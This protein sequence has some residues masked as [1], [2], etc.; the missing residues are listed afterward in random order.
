MIL[1]PFTF[2]KDSYNNE[3]LLEARKLEKLEIQ[4][5][6]SRTAKNFNCRCLA[7]KVTP[8]TLQIKL[9]G[10]RLE[11]AII[12]KAECSL[13]YN[14]IKCTNIKINHLQTKIACTKTSLQ[15]KLDEPT[16]TNLQNTIFNNKAKTFLQYKNTQIKK[17]KLLIS[18]F[19]TTSSKMA[20]KTTNTFNTT[21]TSSSIQDKWVINLSK[22][23]LTPE[24]NSLLQKGP[25]FAVTPANIPIKE[26]MSTTTVATLQA[27]ELNGVDCSDL[28]HDVNR[29]LNTYTTK[30]IHTNI[31]K[32]E[33]LALENLRKDKDH[34][35]VTTDKG[36]ALVVMDKTEYITKCE[37][38]LQD[39]SVYQHL[40]KDTF[41]HIC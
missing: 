21:V 9:N 8:K 32:A 3:T 1:N 38:L 34:I 4:L 20:S 31:T 30:A 27:G 6:K 35:I 7:N 22:K 24:E 23:E 12:K 5:A 19:S 26:Y 36:V 29:I 33:H 17:L 18:R 11:Q 28:Y 16:F 40:S 25:K 10:N 2:I 37:A 14:R 41:Y 13:I 39:H 15:Q